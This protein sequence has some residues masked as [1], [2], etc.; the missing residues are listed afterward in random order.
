MPRSG[1][2]SDPV[3]AHILANPGWLGT[4]RHVLDHPNLRRLSLVGISP[5]RRLQVRW[6]S[7]RTLAR[8][9]R[10]VRESLADTA[11][12]L[13]NLDEFV[14]LEE[15]GRLC[16]FRLE[17]HARVSKHRRNPDGTVWVGLRGRTRLFARSDC[18]VKCFGKDDGVPLT[19]INAVV[20]DGSGGLWLGGSTALVHWHRGS[21]SG[22]HARSKPLS[23]LARAWRNDL[24]GPVRGGPG[25]GLQSCA[26]VF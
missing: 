11:G 2:T 17:R 21:V 20:L 14:R 7:V 9:S 10:C 1:H 18:G 13:G 23:S 4:G 25:L 8:A 15:W 6:R 24:G 16:P 19:D 5:R 3:S 12:D 26:T 22:T